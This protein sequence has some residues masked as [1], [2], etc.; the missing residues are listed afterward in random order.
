MLS[1]KV[2]EKSRSEKERS[3]L[4]HEGQDGILNAQ[5]HAVE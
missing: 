2:T 5:Q 3:R 4:E 1:V